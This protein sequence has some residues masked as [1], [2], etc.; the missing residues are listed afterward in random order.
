MVRHP[1]MS[2][3]KATVIRELHQPALQAIEGVSGDTFA[4]CVLP[5]HVLTRSAA[6]MLDAG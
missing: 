5:T 6:W 4:H 1:M 2:E 3:D